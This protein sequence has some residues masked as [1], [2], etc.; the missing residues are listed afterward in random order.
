MVL[1]KLSYTILLYDPCCK[2]HYLLRSVL[3]SFNSLYLV[4]VLVCTTFLHIVRVHPVLCRNR[5]PLLRCYVETTS[6]VHAFLMMGDNVSTAIA[7]T[8]ITWQRKTHTNAVQGLK[9]GRAC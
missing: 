9:H 7:T 1:P 3:G 5:V 2:S 4:S 6:T 8:R